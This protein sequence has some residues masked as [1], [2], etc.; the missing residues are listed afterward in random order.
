MCSPETNSLM[1]SLHFI[2]PDSKS[3]TFDEKANGYGRGEGSSFLVLKPLEKAVR[4]GDVVRAVIRNTGSNQDGNTPGLTLPS[5][6][7]Q[8]N[9]VQRTYENAGLR[10]ADTAYFE[11]HVS[12]H[13]L[14]L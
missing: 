13:N 5:R 1:S 14:G 8:K 3:Q 12:S 9:L 11:A 10:L 7:S 4:D 2:S 6:T